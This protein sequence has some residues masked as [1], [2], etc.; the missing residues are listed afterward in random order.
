[1]RMR[2]LAAV[3]VLFA[4]VASLSGCYDN[5]WSFSF[6]DKLP[7]DLAGF[8]KTPSDSPKTP[9]LSIRGLG[10]EGI[11][12]L[13]PEMFTSDLKITVEFDLEVNDTNTVDMSVGLVGDR[14]NT[15]IDYMVFNGKKLGSDSGYEFW[16]SEGGDYGY[17]NL[18]ANAPRLNKMGPNKLEL[19][20]KGDTYTAR[21]NGS[22]IEQV[23]AEFCE[24]PAFIP[25]IFSITDGGN[26]YFTSIKVDYNI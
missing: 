8:T 9:V 22:L 6:I 16:T 21:L 20:R 15:P 17:A 13:A 26:I 14:G 4:F 25:A 12:L 23:D 11:A 5:A 18:V 3:L 1:M 2:K 10:L 24:A 7:E 19:V